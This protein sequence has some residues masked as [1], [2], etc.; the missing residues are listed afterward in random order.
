VPVAVSSALRSVFFIAT[1]FGW[2]GAD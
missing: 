2:E 1:V